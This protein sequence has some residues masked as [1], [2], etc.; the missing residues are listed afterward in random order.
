MPFRVDPV[1]IRP[2]LDLMEPLIYP[3]PVQEELDIE[4]LLALLEAKGLRKPMVARV[5]GMTGAVVGSVGEGSG[6]SLSGLSPGLYGLLVEDAV[7]VRV[8]LR[9]LKG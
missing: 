3:N 9:F 4:R 1:G 7:G 2:V 6:G 8:F 5:V